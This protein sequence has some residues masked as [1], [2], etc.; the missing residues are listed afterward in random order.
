MG[1]AFL[2]VK[3]AGYNIVDL[4]V[5][6]KVLSKSVLGGK[7]QLFQALPSGIEFKDSNKDQKGNHS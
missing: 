3:K 4:A 2:G 7:T 1:T 5:P 6:G